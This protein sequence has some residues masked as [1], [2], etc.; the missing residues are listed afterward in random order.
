MRRIYVALLLAM[1]FALL[2][3]GIDNT[4]YNARKYFD[5][6]QAR[7]L[8]ANGRPAPQ[9]VSD[10]TKAIKKCGIILSD[11]GKGKR[12]DDALFLMARAL[13]YKGNSAFQAK[14]AFEG[15]IRGYPNS[16]HIPESYIYLG[17]V[18]RDINQVAESEAV[19]ER[20][21]RDPKFVKDHP[22]A[23]LVMA[24]FEIQDED[25]HRAQYWLE[26]II[27]DYRKTPE[28]KEAAFL[29]GKNY[30]EQGDYTR[31]LQEFETFI[32]TRRIPK[33]QK[34][35]AKYFIGLSHFGLEE[36]D[37]ALKQAK[38]LARN[39]ERPEML[40]RAR[41]LYGRALLAVK[42]V[43]DG[44]KELKE[45]TTSYPRT[46]N[47]AAAYYYWGIYLYYEQGNFDEAVQYLN[48]VRTEFTQSPLA[49]KGTQLATAINKTKPATNL[50]SSRDLQAWLDYHYLRAENLISPLALPDSA[51][52]TYR[53]VI[54]EREYFAAK[55]DSLLIKIEAA[56]N[57]ADSLIAILP[58]PI[59]EAEV[60]SLDTL[61]DA[62]EPEPSETE[63]AALFPA[64][65]SELDSLTILTN[66]EFSDSLQT[67]IDQP[68]PTE[69]EFEPAIPDSIEIEEDEP[70]EPEQPQELSPLPDQPEEALDEVFPPDETLEIKEPEA[71]PALPD[72]IEIVE[73]EPSEQPLEA[74]QPEEALDEEETPE[75]S[76]ETEEQ[77]EINT[78]S[79][80]LQ[81]LQ[82][83]LSTWQQKAEELE[84]LLER[85]DTQIVPFC[86]FSMISLLRKLPD[87]TEE[88]ETL[89][90]IM[91]E[92]YPR[93][94]YSA[95]ATAIKEGRSPRLVDPAYNEALA[96]FDAALDSYPESADSLVMQ[97]QDYTESEYND[98]KLKANYRLG[99]HYSFEDP[100]TTLAK[101]YLSAVL[102]DPQ[103]T[104]YAP[105][106]RRF[107]DGK[108]YL[109]RD[110]GLIDS[111]AVK[112]DSLAIPDLEAEPES[113][114]DSTFT[115]PI[116]Q[117]AAATDSLSFEIELP[118]EV[119]PLELTEPALQDSLLD[120]P[121][122]P[123]EGTT[124]PETQPEEL[125]PD[126]EIQ[127]E[128]GTTEP[129]LPAE[130]AA[131]KPDEAP[132]EEET[133]PV[134]QDLLPPELPQDPQE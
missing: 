36:Y 12:A 5:L 30:Y 3:C 90:Q 7:P 108:N 66:A 20:F 80:L 44:L 59:E 35:E 52:A 105:T 33:P 122:E 119:L 19:L 88:A 98:L 32:N 107:F 34:L 86:Y 47:S 81:E 92:Q 57:K 43:E 95:A 110:S 78:N 17:K 18:L 116:V 102:D 123:Q 53:Q 109:L 134:P 31:S 23:L 13:F 6:A 121:I 48:K 28:F 94:M 111:T 84:P 106:V 100:D 124:E 79:A 120:V 101:A 55:Q 41:V 103:N 8:A 75:A 82:R 113:P 85:F 133:P 117:E 63:I 97:M 127:T 16:K 29:F 118:E 104:E 4:M 40:S 112:A 26:R 11:G 72:A 42:E 24:D 114:A 49:E 131:V 130:E 83:D 14:D 70:L 2:G 64:E 50:D 38:Y 1:L 56:S 22:R 60:D 39:E 45:V 67:D 126:A 93:N 54:D 87:R 73:D 91:L 89:Y 61:T 129:E 21:V 71:E 37:K 15:L 68:L 115:G 62:E 132:S 99:W 76:I 10:Y 27:K 9:A 69:L 96:A 51:L 74:E 58:P 65:P 46:E 25:Y 125:R 77:E 128:E